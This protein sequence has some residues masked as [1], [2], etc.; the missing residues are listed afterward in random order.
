MYKN[1]HKVKE[2]PPVEGS[3]VLVLLKWKEDPES[4]TTEI[5]YYCDHGFYYLELDKMMGVLKKTYLDVPVEYWAKY[6]VPDT[7]ELKG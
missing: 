7:A 1:W 2:F 5:A 6:I 3:A 4:W